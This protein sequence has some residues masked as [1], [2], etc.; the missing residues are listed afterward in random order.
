MLKVDLLPAHYAIAR[1]NRKTIFLSIPLLVGV[2]VLWLLVMVKMNNDITKTTA[3]LEE[4]TRQADAVRKLQ[5]E[6]KAK[7]AELTPIQDK[8]KFVQAADVSGL[9]FFDR[10]D[11]INQYIYDKSVLRN[12]SITPPG[13]VSFSV[14]LA[15]TEDAGRF[16]LNLIRCPYITGIS[17]SGSPGVGGTIEGKGGAAAPSA[18]AGGPGGPGMPPD[19]GGAAPGAPAGGAPAAGA[20]AGPIQL[21]VTA[22]LVEPITIPTPPSGAPAAGPEGAGGPGGPGGPPGGPG[23]PPSGPGG[24]PSG[25]GGPPSGGGGGGGDEA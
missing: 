19:A 10:F 22:T 5:D 9:P 8:V 14:E 16:I 17:I 21:S 15:N 3:E 25:P 13:A 2:A 20:V 12:F 24:P 1:R 23:G 6:T 4:T 18:A 7:Q 11:K